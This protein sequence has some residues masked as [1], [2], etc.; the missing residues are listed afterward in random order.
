VGAVITGFFYGV[1]RPGLNS[2][3]MAFGLAVTV[4]LDFLLIPRYESLGAAIASAIA[5]VTTTLALVALFWWAGRPKRTAL[6]DARLSNAD[7]R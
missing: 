4:V 6:E 2:F 5:Y 3:A 1:G 7:A